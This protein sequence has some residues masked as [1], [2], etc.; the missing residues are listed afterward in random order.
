MII[1]LYS[2]KGIVLTHISADD[3]ELIEIIDEETNNII[4]KINILKNKEV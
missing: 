1:K 3:I 2:N 4:R